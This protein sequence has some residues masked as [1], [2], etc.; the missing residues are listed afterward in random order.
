MNCGT[1]QQSQYVSLLLDDILQLTSKVSCEIAWDTW[2][3]AW[4]QILSILSLLCLA[5]WTPCPEVLSSVSPAVSTLRRPEIKHRRFWSRCTPVVWQHYEKILEDFLWDH[6]YVQYGAEPTTL[7]TCVMSDPSIY[8][9]NNALELNPSSMADVESSIRG[10]AL[11]LISSSW[12]FPLA[13][14]H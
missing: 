8:T 5:A 3:W 9:G 10:T 12:L 4:M 13:I 2:T 7:H 11:Y 1:A 6:S 14:S